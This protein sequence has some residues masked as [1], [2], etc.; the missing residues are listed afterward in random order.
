MAFSLRYPFMDQIRI[1]L[2][3]LT[4][5]FPQNALLLENGH[6]PILPALVRL[7][8]LNWL[9]GTQLLQALTAWLA[10]AGVIAMLLL[11]F[12][13]DLRGNAMIWAS[14]VC[15]ICTMLLWNANARMFIH[16]YEAIQIFYVILFV[17]VAIH[18]AVRASGTDAWKWWIGALVACFAATFTFGMGFG[19][20]AAVAIVAMLRRCG[21]LPLLLIALSA[22]ATFLIY[23]MLLPGAEGVRGVTSGLSI[24]AV[25]FI[26]IARVGAVFA[27]LL[28][29]FVPNP[30]FQTAVSAIAGAVAGAFV[31]VLS[32]RQWIRRTPFVDSSCMASACSFLAWP[33]TR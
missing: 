22:L 20:F 32:I 12:R 13:R 17:V 11:A 15:A 6:R 2:R 3:Y 30:T 28:R 23:Y 5:P 24:P 19:S 14:G 31:S 7:V 27:E 21:R 25:T 9:E 4:I 18:C 16:A 33:P 26:A 10:A 29:L 8:E 1:N